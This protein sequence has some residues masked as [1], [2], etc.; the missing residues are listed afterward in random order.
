MPSP[1]HVDS[2]PILYLDNDICVVDKPPGIFVHPNP[3]DRSAKDC[4]AELK[5]R[6]DTFV[7]TVHRIDRPTSGITVF[8]LHHNAASE[9]SRQIREEGMTKRY[10]S[11]VRGH[12][13]DTIEVDTP[14]PREKTGP[15]VAARSKIMPIAA[16]VVDQPVGRYPQGWFSLV[17]I[18]LYTG[19]YHQARRH[20][21]S[22]GHPVIGDTSHGDH[23]QNLFFRHVIGESRLFLRASYLGFS[24]P[25]TG[26]RIS[27]FAGIPEW[28]R[29]TLERIGIEASHATAPPPVRTRGGPSAWMGPGDG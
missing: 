8:A 20:V 19:R 12:L 10:L 28:W 13:N 22:A 21:R 5:A 7:Y 3:L 27:C 6:L 1:D 16:T 9:L 14:I 17:E 18:E 26:H 29:E 2:I 11:L 23:A 4:V 24:H 15:K 25:V